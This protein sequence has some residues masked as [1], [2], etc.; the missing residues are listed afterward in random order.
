MRQRSDPPKFKIRMAAQR[1]GVS[2]RMILAE[3]SRAK[4][5]I[6][7]APQRERF[8]MHHPRRGFTRKVPKFARRHNESASTLT[9]PDTGAFRLPP[10]KLTLG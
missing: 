3:G 7:T 2:T 10:A 1:C 8:D 6:R 4:L 5:K 9:I